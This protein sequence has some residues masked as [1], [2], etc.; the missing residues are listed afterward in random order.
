[1][2]LI[3]AVDDSWGIGTDNKLLVS[4]KEDMAFFRRMTKGKVVVMGRKTLE[5]LPGK[6]GLPDRTNIVMTR[7]PDFK[8]DRCT[9]VSTDDDLFH[10]IA[11]YEPDDVF[12]IGGESIYR[13][14]YSLCDKLYI[15][16]I[17]ADFGADSFMVNVDM[18]KNFHII[19]ESRMYTENGINYKF[20]TYERIGN[21]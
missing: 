7:S 14:F 15:T 6:K 5:S 20:F 13:Q 11:R 12:I 9:V 19:E 2:N 10:E 3:V 1:M 18:D 16:K 17:Y 21:E 8:A 4:L